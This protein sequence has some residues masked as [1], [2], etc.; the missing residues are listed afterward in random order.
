M[1]SL[2]IAATTTGATSHIPHK[3]GKSIRALLLA[4][5]RT[6]RL[7]DII[8][9]P[10]LLALKKEVL[11]CV[12]P[13]FRNIP[14]MDDEEL[15]AGLLRMRDQGQDPRF[16]IKLTKTAKLIYDGKNTELIGRIIKRTWPE[17]ECVLQYENTTEDDDAATL[18]RARAGRIVRANLDKSDRA[19]QAVEVYL[20]QKDN[21]KAIKAAGGRLKSQHQLAAEHGVSPTYVEDLLRVRK[22]SQRLYD[23]VGGRKIKVRS[24]AEIADDEDEAMCAELLKMF[25]GTPHLTDDDYRR[26]LR[27][28]RANAS[29]KKRGRAGTADDRPI[30]ADDAVKVPDKDAEAERTGRPDGADAPDEVAETADLAVTDID[31]SNTGDAIP[32]PT[33][34]G[35]PAADA[36]SLDGAGDDPPGREPGADGV[37]ADNLGGFTEFLPALKQIHERLLTYPA[38]LAL[39]EAL[40]TTLNAARASRR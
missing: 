8:D 36:S 4:R 32:P 21:K 26:L 28:Y 29:Q 24:A 17:F 10:E 3:W 40:E 11:E 31:R 20:A 19:F 2:A 27:E 35:P 14:F 5:G 1:K 25:E 30:V 33:P 15:R 6:V 34:V 12:V 16:P 9:E 37:P 39:I 7:L 38:T 22:K 23:L 13:R 18:D